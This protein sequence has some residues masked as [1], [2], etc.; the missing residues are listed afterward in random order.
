[1]MEWWKYPTVTGVLKLSLNPEDPVQAMR[2][3][4]DGSI[5]FCTHQRPSVTSWDLQTGGFIRTSMPES[6]LEDLAV[7]LNGHYLA[8]RLLECVVKV[9]EVATERECVVIEGGLPDTHLC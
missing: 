8:C 3:S 7:S 5:L 6:I 9:W 4:P 1:M 2:G